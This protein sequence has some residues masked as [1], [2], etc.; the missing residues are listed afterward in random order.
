VSKREIEREATYEDLLRVPDE[1]IA[2]LIDGD[3]FASPRPQGRHGRAMSILSGV[4]VNPFDRGIG[5]PGGWWIMIE[6]EIHLGRNIFVPDLCG[7]RR[8]TLPEFPPGPF[9]EVP[10]DW[11]CEVASPRTAR[12]DRIK[13]MPA[14]ARHD[15]PHVWIIDPESRSLEVFRLNGEHYSLMDAYG[16]DDV[17]RV[18]PFDEIELRLTDF[19]IGSDPLHQQ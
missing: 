17:A 13:K 16:G 14:Y 18:E 15:V 9:V 5:G 4:L 7:W 2:E 19:W 8:E 1:F 6:P 10:P 3:L 12:L 11:V